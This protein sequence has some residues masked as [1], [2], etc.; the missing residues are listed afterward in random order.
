MQMRGP[1]ESIMARPGSRKCAAPDQVAARTTRTGTDLYE[2][3]PLS[4]SM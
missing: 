3:V 1:G 2:G 4:L